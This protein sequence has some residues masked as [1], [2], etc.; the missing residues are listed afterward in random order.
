LAALLLF[1]RRIPGAWPAFAILG[2]TLIV[3]TDPFG[4]ISL[5]VYRS[6]VLADVAR[7]TYFLGGVTL[8]AALLTALSIDVFL[9]N[10][11][12]LPVLL[13]RIA[14]AAMALWIVFDLARW[15]GGGS[16]PAGWRGWYDVVAPALLVFGGL[17]VVRARPASLLPVMML[18]LFVIVNF[19]VLGTNKHFNAAPGPGMTYREDSYVAMDPEAYRTL[20][21]YPRHRILIDYATG[22]VPARVRHVGLQSP[23]G[24]DPFLSAGLRQLLIDNGATF[25]N[26]REFELDPANTEML[27]LLGVRFF[28]T[29][30]ES[31]M[32]AKLAGNPRFRFVGQRRDFYRVFEYLDAREPFRWAGEAKSTEWAPERRVFVTDS[33]EGGEFV[34]A[35]QFHPRWKATVDGIELPVRPWKNAFHAVSMPP[36]R[37]T[38]IFEFRPLWQ[39]GAIL[40]LVGLTILGAWIAWARARPQVGIA[41]SA[42]Q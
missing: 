4:W 14:L 8:S 16:F 5:L 28:I 1:R 17:L 39:T 7:S 32:Y 26:E 41:S 33:Q 23:Q 27:Q 25:R 24:F 38:L 15:F 35:E 13:Q 40:T 36:G 18:A 34:L 37:H 31:P 10:A 12:D 21:A 30:D 29:G 22:P 6:E 11:R 2:A 42:P 9:K 19:K 3:V 20:L